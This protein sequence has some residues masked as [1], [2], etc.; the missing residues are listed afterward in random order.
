[1][2]IAKEKIAQLK[3]SINEQLDTA[4]WFNV[5][6]DVSRASESIRCKELQD[7]ISR[8]EDEARSKSKSKASEKAET[9][10]KGKG[11]KLWLKNILLA[12]F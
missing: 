9:G 5:D 7:L 8:L 1:M 11:R 6:F 2:K 12:E 3:Y 4:T 10:T